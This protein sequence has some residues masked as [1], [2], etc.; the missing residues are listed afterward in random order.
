M[1]LCIMYDRLWI[2]V[3]I[4]MCEHEALCVTSVYINICVCGVRHT[5]MNEYEYWHNANEVLWHMHMN[6]CVLNV[7]SMSMDMCIFENW[8]E[9]VY[10]PFY[11]KVLWICICVM[12]GNWWCNEICD[13][14]ICVM[15]IRKCVSI[16]IHSVMNMDDD[17]V[18]RHMACATWTWSECIWAHECMRNG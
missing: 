3:Y 10:V 16:C 8:Y 12:Y 15:W 14:W 4:Y 17:C 13:V 6:M 11:G 5:C 9:I 18:W 7:K 1:K 2:S